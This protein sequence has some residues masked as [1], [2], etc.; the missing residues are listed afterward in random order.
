MRIVTTEHGDVQVDIDEPTGTI[1]GVYCAEHKHAL[2]PNLTERRFQCVQPIDV[3]IELAPEPGVSTGRDAHTRIC[4]V[5]VTQV[6][7]E[8]LKQQCWH[9]IRE[10]DTRENRDELQQRDERMAERHE[11]RRGR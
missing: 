9:E 7:L 1:R 8:N 11:E 6:Q 5:T 4:P 3:A 10:R 2:S